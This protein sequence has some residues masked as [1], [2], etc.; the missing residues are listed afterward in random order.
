MSR[1]C[2][3]STANLP[4]TYYDR[5]VASRRF[6]GSSGFKQEERK[7]V[8]Q[9]E[10]KTF[11]ELVESANLG[12]RDACFVLWQYYDEESNDEHDVNLAKYWCQ[13]AAVR[14]CSASRTRLANFDLKARDRE[15]AVR[16]LMISCRQGND[17]GLKLLG[18][19]YREGLKRKD[20]C[21]TK[22]QYAEALRIHK[23]FS[24]S[25][26]S[27]SRENAVAICRGAK[28]IFSSDLSPMPLTQET[29][30]S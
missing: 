12:S 17:D 25:M 1:P 20:P 23:K 27:D 6:Y 29:M 10:E 30:I 16:H 7:V 8:E 5:S 3:I 13:L 14:G 26:T 22:D 24:D 11:E 28:S 9:D 21:V 2:L 15:S 19:L 18:R 4:Y